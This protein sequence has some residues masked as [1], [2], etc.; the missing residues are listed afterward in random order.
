MKPFEV[1]RERE[2]IPDPEAREIWKSIDPAVRRVLRVARNSKA[3]YGHEISLQDIAYIW[4]RQIPPKRFEAVCPGLGIPLR[5][6]GLYRPY[7]FT[8]EPN[9]GFSVANCAIVSQAY[10]ILRKAD[11]QYGHAAHLAVFLLVQSKDDIEPLAEARDQQ[12]GRVW[13]PAQHDEVLIGG[14][15]QID[16]QRLSAEHVEQEEF[17]AIEC[18]A[19]RDRDHLG[20][21]LERLEPLNGRDAGH[22]MRVDPGD[23]PLPGDLGFASTHAFSVSDALELGRTVGRA[24][25]RVIVIGVE[26]V[27]FGMGDPVTPEV[28]ATLDVV[29]ESV[30]DELAG[31]LGD[32]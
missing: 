1:D 12:P 2:G 8:V 29:A 28:E 3:A 21:F 11:R 4:G 16:R 23:G 22:P 30:L 15:A 32:A 9:M 14:V 25:H 27:A 31:G 17:V 26:G 7:L 20:R 10:F 24:P 5:A 13:Q 19:R 6:G 18:A